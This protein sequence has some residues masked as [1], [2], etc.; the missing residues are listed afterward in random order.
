MWDPDPGWDDDVPHPAAEAPLMI[1]WNQEVTCETPSPHPVSQS[2]RAETAV[3]PRDRLDELAV[4]VR[5][6][7]YAEMLEFAQSVWS[8]RGN[9]R[10]TPETLPRILHGWAR[11]MEEGSAWRARDAAVED[12]DPMRYDIQT[13][14]TAPRDRPILAYMVG[15]WRV[16]RWDAAHPH[17]KPVPFWAAD[18]LRVTVSRSH[19]PK[20]WVELPTAPPPATEAPEIEASAVEG[21]GAETPGA[22]TSATE[23]PGAEASGA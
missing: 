13:I 1:T 6:L 3:P 8:A 7:T 15:R 12:R 4:L 14:D 22:E 5:A 20:W 2:P 9:H 16:A 11:K 17:K 10:M 21:S 23:A 18:D 19:Q